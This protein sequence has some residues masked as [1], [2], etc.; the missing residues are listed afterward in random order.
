MRYRVLAS[1]LLLISLILGVWPLALLCFI[2]T[3]FPLL[4]KIPKVGFRYSFSLLMLFFFTVSLFYGGRIS[5]IFFLAMA[6]VPF[7]TCV[8]CRRVVEVKDSFLVRGMFVPLI[9]YGVAKVKFSSQRYAEC[10][11]LMP[12]VSFFVIWRGSLYAFFSCF[13]FRRKSAG[14]KILNKM[15]N[16]LGAVIHRGAYLFPLCPSSF[17][18][19]LCS[20]HIRDKSKG[21]MRGDVISFKKSGN[22]VTYISFYKRSE[23]P[24]IV[25]YP[26]VGVS[27]PLQEVLIALEHV[28]MPDGELSLLLATLAAL[29]A[30]L[31]DSI[32]K[33]KV[34][35][36][37]VNV[38][39]LSS[40]SI[41]MD[42]KQFDVILSLYAGI[43]R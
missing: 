42:E 36:D 39:V 5:S 25:P 1:V 18:E 4:R 41:E 30:G 2:Y 24:M 6:A 28:C 43:K 14:R 9:W 33:E 31:L 10:I 11:S 38:R 23:G 12:D 27:E 26:R 22:T 35:G 37:K 7:A 29:R 8:A 19:L 34:E 21:Y 15:E 16:A 3:A 13:S 32:K 20:K 40:P 17:S